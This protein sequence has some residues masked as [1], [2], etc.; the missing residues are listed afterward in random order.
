MSAQLHRDYKSLR[1]ELDRLGSGIAALVC[2]LKHEDVCVA[3]DLAHVL[4]S[5][6]CA[7]LDAHPEHEIDAVGAEGGAA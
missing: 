4:E 2:A 7:V 5:H 1:T 3:I 6:A